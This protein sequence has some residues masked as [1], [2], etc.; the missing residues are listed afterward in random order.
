MPL[1][2]ELSHQPLGEQLFSDK[3]SIWCRLACDILYID[4]A[5]LE[6]AVKSSP[7]FLP[8]QCWE[9]S[10]TFSHNTKPRPNSKKL[11]TQKT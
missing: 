10:Q 3:V 5:G 4:Q 1:L 8:S 6:S 9:V 2:T 11:Q 7:L